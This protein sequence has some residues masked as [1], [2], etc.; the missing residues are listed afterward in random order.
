MT[1]CST[2]RFNFQG[3]AS[4]P[5]G[6]VDVTLLVSTNGVLELCGISSLNTDTMNTRITVKA[7]NTAVFQDAVRESSNQ[8]G[9]RFLKTIKMT[10]V[11]IIV[12]YVQS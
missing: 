11:N 6:H 5:R 3:T 7:R 9:T 12:K 4:Y 2:I 10:S 1:S 8:Q